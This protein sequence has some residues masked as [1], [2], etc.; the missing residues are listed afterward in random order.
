M[1]AVEQN[2]EIARRFLEFVSAHNIEELCKMVTADWSMQGGPPDLPLGPA[3]IRQLFQTFGPIQQQWSI[4]ELIAEEDKVAVRATNTC[5]Q[6]SFLGINSDGKQQVFTA[7]FIHHIVQGKIKQTWRN[8]NDLGRLLQL[9]ARI[10]PGDP[11][12]VNI[13][14]G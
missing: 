7:M 5:T 4:E 6:E 12:P 8:A 10:V 11:N 2:K 14:E 13:N 1:S 3:G 9:G